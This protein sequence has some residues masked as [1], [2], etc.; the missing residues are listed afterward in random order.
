MEDV[1]NEERQNQKR[2]ESE[3]EKNKSKESCV[4]VLTT[5][6]KSQLAR[7]ARKEIPAVPVKDIP[8]PLVS[9]KKER[10]R[11][12]AR[13]LDIFKKLEIIIPFGEALQQMPIYI[14][15]LKEM[16]MKKGKYINNESIMVEGNYNVVI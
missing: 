12:F 13:F 7:E 3:K 4:K 14:K 9:S 11:C 15:F 5:K 1:V 6:T 16:F 10:E 2:E 8:Y